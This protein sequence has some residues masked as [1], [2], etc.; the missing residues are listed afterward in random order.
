M[1]VEVI[2]KNWEKIYE[3]ETKILDKLGKLN[4]PITV[5]GSTALSR[6]Y[7]NHRDSE[8]LELFLDEF[9]KESLEKVLSSLK[10]SFDIISEDETNRWEKTYKI[11]CRKVTVKDNFIT[12]PVVICENPF[13]DIFEK[14]KMERGLYL[15]SIEGIYTKLILDVIENPHDYLK[16]FDIANIDNEY[17]LIDFADDV[18]EKVGLDKS[19]LIQAINEALE[20]FNTFELQ[21]LF[22]EYGI[23]VSPSVMRK[24]LEAKKEELS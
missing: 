24:W 2:M 16:W 20:N 23:N 1:Y 7:F 13:K 15:D 3:T 10:E 4:L 22:T 14:V 17:H 8:G 12:Y 9:S 18:K 11:R 21:R 19:L 5:S 6:G